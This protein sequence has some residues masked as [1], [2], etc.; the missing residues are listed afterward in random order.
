MLRDFWF[1]FLLALAG[2]VA[3]LAG[4]AFEHYSRRVVFSIAVLLCALAVLSF[5]WGDPVRGPF[6]YLVKPRSSEQFSLQAG[7]RVSFPVR[8]LKEGID[9][10][11][12]IRLPGQPIVVWIRRT[13]WSGWQYRVVLKG[14]GGQPVV[15]FTN[16]SVDLLPPGWDLNADENAMEVVDQD[17]LPRFQLV[18]DGDCNVYINTVLS[19]PEQSIVFKDNRLE[20]KPTAQLTA[21]DF[22]DRLFRYPSYAHRGGRE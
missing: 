15:R 12:A 18:Q 20:F 8:E 19:G 10:S 11:R 5:I 3:G 21:A 16:R 2:I 13:W 7:A 17:R 14:A 1:P 6:A 22:P 9:F 4:L